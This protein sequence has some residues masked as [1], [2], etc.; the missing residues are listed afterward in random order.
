[1]ERDNPRI[2][3]TPVASMPRKKRKR[4]HP[5]PASGDTASHG[6]PSPPTAGQGTYWAGLITTVLFAN[7]CI[8]T[9][10]LLA[11]RLIARFL[12]QSLY[13][14]TTI[15]GVVLAGMALGNYL[16]GRFADRYPARRLLALLLMAASLASLSVLGMNLWIGGA[17]GMREL[18][19]PLRTVIHIGIVFLLPSVLLGTINPVAA[20]SAL[21]CGKEP[22]RAVGTI[23]AAAAAGSIGGTFLTGFVLMALLGYTAIIHSI[24]GVLAAL[25]LGYAISASPWRT[26]PAEHQPAELGR[27]GPGPDTQAASSA[28]T[29]AWWGAIALAF[30]ANAAFMVLE[31]CASRMATGHLGQS[32]YTWTTLLGTVLA[33]VTIGNYLGGNLADRHEPRRLLCVLLL[34]AALALLAVPALNT[35]LGTGSVLDRLPWVQ[36]IAI[37]TLLAFF[38]PSVLLGA[39]GPAIARLALDMG[40]PPGRTLGSVYAWGSLGAV[41]GT[42]LTG[43]LLIDRVH[44]TGTLILLSLLLASAGTLFS[45]DRRFGFGTVL[46]GAIALSAAAVPWQPVRDL[47]EILGLRDQ[48]TSN[49][50]YT[51]HSQY[52][53]I[54]VGAEPT[55][56]ELRY[57]YLDQLMHSKVDVSNPT[58]L[59]YDYL[60]IYDAIIE[61]VHPDQRPVASLMIGGGGYAFPRYLELTRPGSHIEVVEIDPA[62][63]DAARKALGFA[64]ESSVV[65]HHADARNHVEDL[66]RKK[67]RLPDQF[68]LDIV[69][70]DA[71]NQFSVPF[72]LTT[73]EFGQ[74]L[75]DLLDDDGLYLFNLVDAYSSAGLLGSV[76]ASL[77]AVFPYVYVLTS[78]AKSAKRDTF[79]VVSSKKELDLS[80]V[81]RRLREQSAY[82]GDL[83]SRR[84]VVLLTRSKRPLS[85][86]YAPVE[87]LL[88]GLVG[89]QRADRREESAATLLA[90]GAIAEAVPILRS[91]S[92]DEPD[93]LAVRQL[94]GVALAKL[95]QI[96]EAIDVF[97]GILS[98]QPDNAEIHLNLAVILSRT[99]RLAEAIPHFRAVLARD[100]DSAVAHLVLGQYLASRSEPNEALGHL[101]AA[102]R[103]DSGNPTAHRVLGQFQLS[104]GHNAQAIA[105]LTRAL[106]LDPSSAQAHYSI[107]VAYSRQR[108]WSSARR[109]LSD[110]IRLEPNNAQAHYLLG[111]VTGEEGDLAGAR[112]HYQAAIRIRPEFA[113]A[114]VNLGNVHLR[115]GRTTEARDQYAAALRLRPDYAPA[116]FNLGRILIDLGEIPRAISH[117]EKVL[118]LQPD[119]PNAREEL[120]RALALLERAS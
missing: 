62:V 118:E 33:G 111:N 56:P 47:G 37:H 107:G 102:A 42:F 16:G 63:T 84:E 67:S 104:H 120:A 27:A 41:V 21:G 68:A 46:A 20:R 106:N 87:N 77:E 91:V 6:Y 59:L 113:A 12:G 81:P 14:W 23:Y 28:G 19:W 38:L 54:R 117:L 52:S 39:I 17:P 72:Q 98:A 10:E 85:D 92:A 40:G 70:G 82:V 22:G 76:I 13:T 34:L 96:S 49:L 78:G 112:G 115:L 89:T 74:A 57:L 8:M 108:D 100:P 101:A 69:I 43:F 61:Q 24:A 88:A 55:R 2:A 103:L 95:G 25:G 18:S 44:P 86:D 79:V 90:S 48:I 4:R 114:H 58:Q 71:F 105:H 94:L 109:H 35:W 53:W 45:T 66:L 80:G 97:D 83:L 5:A 9:L 50:I 30:L 119:F 32:L 26:A 75:Y 29:G 116:H 3:G 64:P 73:A 60:K 110:S 93:N 31:L 7:A 36:R 99:G 65:V 11:G 51:D 15:I 1:M